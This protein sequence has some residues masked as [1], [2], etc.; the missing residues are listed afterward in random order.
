MTPSAAIRAFLSVSLCLSLLPACGGG[1]SDR[2]GPSVVGLRLTGITAP[3]GSPLALDGTLVFR[4]TEAVDEA[5][6][7]DDAIVIETADGRRAGGTF[8]RERFLVDPDTGTT[9]V[10]DPGPLGRGEIERIERRGDAGLVPKSVRYDL[11]A[12][13]R[14][15]G[16]RQVLFDRSK[17]NVVMFVP[18]VPA[19]SGLSD[20]G[21]APATAYRIRIAVDPSPH[22]LV[23]EFGNALRST[24]GKPYRSSFATKALGEPG[25]F[26]DEGASGAPGVVYTSP[27]N[28]GDGIS[29]D[30]WVFILFS[31]PLD[32]STVTPDQFTLEIVSVAGRPAVSFAS[33]RLQTWTGPVVVRLT[34]LTDFPP[35]Q[36]FEVSVGSG[37]RD[38]SGSPLPPGFRFS[39]SSTPT[40][41]PIT[42][43]EP[44]ESHAQRDA[45]NTTAEWNT[46]V[47]GA[48]EGLPGDGRE[49]VGQSR[50][51][52]QFFPT[53][54]YG[55]AEIEADR[56]GGSIAVFVQGSSQDVDLPGTQPVDPDDDP[57]RIHTTNWVP[58][59]RAAELIYHQYVRF[60]VLLTTA[61]DGA[62][63]GEVPVV[64]SLKIPVRSEF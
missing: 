40:V 15:N 34:P 54:Y 38:F 50:W 10:V 63:T 12:K 44:F 64:W 53:P 32:P 62:T 28:G 1:L 8:V 30:D 7:S 11:G 17:K 37:I 56:N 51:Y 5:S 39:F 19:T 16:N 22:A 20:T 45:A 29:P 49:S 43:I 23:S 25:C 52:N 14:Y 36:W 21:Y 24:D 33:T 60:R 9:V 18:E 31:R 26:L 42:I 35:N 46:T 41:P 58:G 59:D 6:L 27:W 4:F 47:P 2:G 48:L 13:S 61:P 57:Q 55:T 3:G